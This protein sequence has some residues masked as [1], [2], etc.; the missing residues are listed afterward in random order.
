MRIVTMLFL[1]IFFLYTPIT[2]LISM[3]VIEELPFGWMFLSS[4]ASLPFLLLTRDDIK[5]TVLGKPVIF[6]YLFLCIFSAVLILNYNAAN[7]DLVKG[8]ISNIIVLITLYL[9]ASK[10]DFSNKFFKNASLITFV[11]SSLF[12]LYNRNFITN[13]WDYI[14]VSL[15]YQ[16]IGM[17]YFL[18]SLPIF[19]H[20]NKTFR[21][22]CFIICLVCLNI[23]G[24]RTEM[25]SFLFI[26]IILEIFSRPRRIRVFL[27]LAL[28][29]LFLVFMAVGKDIL[30]L[31][32][33]NKM[34]EVLFN[35]EKDESWIERKILLTEGI[36]TIKSN[37]F[38]GKYGS[39]DEG[40]YIHNIL[41]AWVDLGFLGFT[42]LVLSLILTVIESLKILYNEQ[43]NKK[44]VLFLGFTLT[45]FVI[46]VFSKHYTYPLIGF[47]IGL[48]NRFSTKRYNLIF[49]KK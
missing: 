3:G 27:L 49:N 5:G 15:N 47:C 35:L 41:S 19:M 4:I 34:S 31:M 23:I 25:F 43:P 26:I 46:S 13:F 45:I 42:T 39:Y 6:F 33:L 2:V 40:E 44:D 8:H 12:I 11:L 24:A 7:M 36:R 21:N 10:I 16:G 1:L 22:T 20:D 32:G 18:L 38:W 48:Y 14:D 29:I 17:C 28:I 30:D 37:F 9:L